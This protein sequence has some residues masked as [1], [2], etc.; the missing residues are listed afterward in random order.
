MADGGLR[1]TERGRQT[2]MDHA[3]ECKIATVVDPHFTVVANVR[4]ATLLRR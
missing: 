3:V 1:L 2:F 4:K